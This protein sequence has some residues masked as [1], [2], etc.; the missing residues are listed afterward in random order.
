MVATCCALLPL[1]TLAAPV[2]SSA[3]AVPAMAAPHPAV[4]PAAADSAPG[5]PRVVREFPAVEVRALLLDARA[6]R[7]VRAIHPATLRSYPVDGLAGLIAL[8]PGVVPH[9]DELHVRGGRAGETLS[10]LDGVT[11]NEPLRGRPLEVPLLA[12]RGAEVVS[13]APESRHAGSLA[14]AIDLQPL[15]PG[16]RPSG[17]WRWQSDGGLDTRFDRVSARLSAPLGLGG[18]GVVAAGDARLDDTAMPALRSAGRRRVAGVRFGWRAENRLLG[19]LRLAPVSGPRRFAAH[20]LAARTVRRPYDPAWTLDGWTGFDG[21]GLPAFS[22]DPLPGYQRYRAADHLGMSDERRLAALL[23]AAG[24]RGAGRGTLTLGWLR[25]R[26]ASGVGAGWTI[27][28][29]PRPA[30]FDSD[31]SGDAFH[32]IGGDDPLF[33]VSGSDV[34]SLRGDAEWTT[35]RGV[36]LRA[37]LGASREEVWLDELDATLLYVAGAPIDSVRSFRARAPG[38]IAYAQARWTAGE[39]VLNA[40]LRAELFTPGAEGARQTLPGSAAARVSLLPRFGLAFPV[41]PRDVVSVSYTRVS[42]PPARDLL[43]DRRRAITNRQPLGNPALPPARMI[44]WEGAL[45]HLFGP[46]WS[47]QSSFFYRDVAR[48][49]GARDY[50][51]PGGAV[52]DLRY[53]DEDQASAAGIELA[54]ARDGGERGRLEAHYT[55]LHAWGFESRPEGDPYGPVRE[56][57]TAPIAERPLSWDRRHTLAVTGFWRWR[58]R[59]RIAWSSRVESPLPWTPK[60]RRQPPPDVT[61]VHSRRFGWTATSDVGASWSPPY[62]LGLVF[63][64]E[65]RNLFDERGALAATVDGYPNPLINTVFDDYGAHR[66]E[67][68][69]GGGAYWTNAGGG[70]WVP[71]ND[72]RLARAPRTVRASVGRSW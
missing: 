30:D 17:E 48:Q 37:G 70:R 12:L 15:E 52:V 66:T 54:L 34:L 47:L 60:P 36:A 8:Q 40:G 45:L 39:M 6:S 32:V 13:G 55:L 21:F 11:L 22:P 31:A 33:R 59:V 46:A 9:G 71:V 2:D 3:G 14:G 10:L 63:G 41:S 65:V 62:A 19:S 23:T 51:T 16:P 24:T 42:Q 57:G 7:T 50:R 35:R 27:P 26:A 49:A 20:L 28:G 64:L 1:V 5:P 44:S 68:G 61:A 72:P 18:L 29:A 67:T 53:T 38:G 43:Y 69:L 56:P 58:E 4:A 25:T